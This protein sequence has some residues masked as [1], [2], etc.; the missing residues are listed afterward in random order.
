MLMTRLMWEQRSTAKIMKVLESNLRA[1]H[2]NGILQ[3]SLAFQIEIKK[4]GV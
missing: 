2:G 3:T 4:M 1:N